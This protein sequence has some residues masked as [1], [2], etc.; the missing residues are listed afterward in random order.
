MH[1][2]RHLV[3]RPEVD[4]EVEQAVHQR[5]L[6]RTVVAVQR[7]PAG[8][9]GL[10]AGTHWQ[11]RAHRVRWLRRM[12]G[13]R[14]P[15]M[16][17]SKKNDLG[18]HALNRKGKSGSKGIKPRGRSHTRLF[19]VCRS[20]CIFSACD[21][22]SEKGRRRRVRTS[23]RVCVCGWGGEGG[24]GDGWPSEREREGHWKRAT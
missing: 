15:S 4:E 17:C 16:Q 7:V 21:W 19:H 20:T 8:G 3:R 22:A 12:E 9:G 13:I 11:G 6:R 1:S 10:H 14:P 24:E 23:V 2:T 5:P 18:A